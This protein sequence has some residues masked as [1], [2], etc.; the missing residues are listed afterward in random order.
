MQNQDDGTLPLERA[1]AGREQRGLGLNRPC[2]AASLTLHIALIG[3]LLFGPGLFAER[4]QLERQ[5]LEIVRLP[6]IRPEPIPPPPPQDESQPE[7]EPVPEPE[8]EPEPEETPPDV[9]PLAPEE[10]EPDPEPAPLPPEPE[11]EP[12]PER[13]RL[14]RPFEPTRTVDDALAGTDDAE[15]PVVGYDSEDFTYAYYTSRL[16]AA[17]KARWTRPPIEGVEAVVFFRIGTDGTVSDLELLQSSGVTRFDSAGLRA[18]ELASP[19]PPLPRSF[20]KPSLGVTM[21]IR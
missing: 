6:T 21:T 18:I 4:T 11:P 17:I 19:V 16:I 14:D 8:P 1:L 5:P 15:A 3:G 13:P 10:P 7:P 9:P 2:L 20:R 12:E